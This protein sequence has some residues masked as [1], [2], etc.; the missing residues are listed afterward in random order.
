MD[1][2][3]MPTEDGTVLH[4]GRTP[5]RDAAV[6]AMLRAA[7]AV[8]MGKTVTTECAAYAP[9]KTRNPHNPGHTPGGSSSGSAAAVAAGMVPLALGSQTNGS[10]IRPAAFCGV[11]GF[12]PTHGLIPRAGILKLSR[13]LDHV[14]VFAR[15]IEDIAL[16]AEQLVGYDE[17]D[18]DTRPRAR[19]P[20]REAVAQEPPLPPL[21][22]F[23]KG[24]V[25][26]RAEEETTQAF[27]ELVAELGDRVVE[28]VLPE[29]AQRALDWHRTIMET[30]M[31]ANLD[32]EWEKGRDR[33]SE[34]LRNQLAR[35]REVRAL[36]YHKALA[37]VPLVNEGFAELFARYDAILTPAAPGTAPKG[38]GATGDPAFCTLWTLSGMPAVALPL[39]QGENGLPLGVQLVG[40]RHGDAR[41]LRTASW[42][43]GQVDGNRKSTG[44]T[45]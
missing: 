37:R 15:T 34:S 28:V 7:G 14:G 4:A 43:T 24:P 11:Y 26:E 10:V 33:L 39:M 36:D 22:A 38:L 35:G 27:A 40:P 13:T 30:E 12:K 18:P 16:I 31:A 2:A 8:I 32:L 3:D 29:T 41:L 25:W 17:D 44:G 45:A 19:P 9:G 1:T 23:V 5:A 21:L 20:Y 42:L 6:V